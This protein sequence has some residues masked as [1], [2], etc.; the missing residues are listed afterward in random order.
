ML[1]QTVPGARP[2]LV[3]GPA[4]LGHPN[5]WHVKRAMANHGLQRRKDLLVGQIAR[6]A[7]EH[8]GVR[9]VP[10]GRTLSLRHF[11]EG[12]AGAARSTFQGQ[13]PAHR[14]GRALA[15]PLHRLCACVRRPGLHRPHLPE[16]A[17]RSCPDGWSVICQTIGVL[18]DLQLG[19]AVRSRER[20][21]QTTVP[22]GDTFHPER[23]DP[24]GQRRSHLHLPREQLR[25]QPEPALDPQEDRGR[26]ASSAS[27]HGFRM[28]RGSPRRSRSRAR[29]RSE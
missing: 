25:G 13:V 8:Q 6:C 2:E 19:C 9:C 5:D 22:D 24:G 12:P 23:L 27:P 4:R 17:P 3:E 29:S 10:T 15:R 7:E 28:S 18:V 26:R 14:G 21:A 16:T 20:Q 1:H 11:G